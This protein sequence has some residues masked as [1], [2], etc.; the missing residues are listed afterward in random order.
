MAK[1]KNKESQ[2]LTELEEAKV[3]AAKAEAEAIQLREEIARKNDKGPQNKQQKRV[4]DHIDRPDEIMGR[5]LQTALVID[6]AKFTPEQKVA[7][8]REIRRYVKA[9]GRVKDRIS[10]QFKP[11]KA[12]W[13][14]GITP[15]QKEYATM[16]L[17]KMGRVD[18][19]GEVIPE[20]DTSVVPGMESL[21][22]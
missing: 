1:K 5:D 16:L 14:K 13:K 17:K 8:E 19:K 2:Q 22:R 4:V 18:D 11:I 7:V 15:E 20:W 6:A 12:G 10:G 3:K 9:G 21:P